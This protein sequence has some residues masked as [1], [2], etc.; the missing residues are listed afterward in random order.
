MFVSLTA[1]LSL[2]APMKHRFAPALLAVCLIATFAW[3]AQPDSSDSRNARRPASDTRAEQANPFNDEPVQMPLT[4]QPRLTRCLVSCIRE[5]Q[6]AA[7]EAGVLVELPAIEGQ[8][9]EAGEQL[10]KI[11]DSQPLMQGKAA[12]AELRAAE[13][14]AKSDVDERYA[15]KASEVAK[16]EWEK[17]IEANQKTAGSISQVEVARLKLTWERG[18]L[19]IER[20]QTERKMSGHTAD[21][22]AVEVDAAKE[23]MKRRRI[24][25]PIDGNVQQVNLHKGEWVKPGDPVVHVVQL[26]RLK[27]EGFAKLDETV[28]QQL[29]GKPV[30]VEVTIA[31]QKLRFPG[32]ITFVSLIVRGRSEYLV[33]AEVDNRKE[34]GQWL[35]L[36]GMS[37]EMVIDTV[38]RTTA[39]K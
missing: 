26:D 37:A 32:R 15:K 18:L 13:E 29:M 36:P 16:K 39:R 28:P 23:A 7:Q 31:E 33:K 30:V 2:E 21:A 3:A 8:Q 19:E 38:G 17:A 6:V 14:K 20:A 24:T 27:V 4:S 11:D 25:S 22:K 12:M 10:G 1:W 9:V 35:L 34:N 5:A